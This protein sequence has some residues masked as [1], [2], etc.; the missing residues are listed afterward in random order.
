MR[1]FL[2]LLPILLAGCS[3][4]AF[5]QPRSEATPPEVT[6]VN[7]SSEKNGESPSKKNTGRKI[8][9][10]AEL[11]L[12]VEDFAAAKSAVA[13]EVASV[14]GHIEQHSVDRS[15]GDQVTGQ[16]IL[17]TP[18]SEFESVLQSLRDLGV[19]EFE[20]IN[21]TDKTA[22]H[23]DLTARIASQQTL[24]QRLLTLLGEKADDLKSIIEL[25]T[26]LSEVRRQIE[27]LQA[28]LRVL[29]DQIAMTTIT[30]Q[31][32]EEKN[33]TPP[34]AP[35][36]AAQIS[37][38]FGVSVGAMLEA[39]KS[40]VL[41]LVAVGPWLLAGLVLSSPFLFWGFVWRQRQTT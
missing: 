32:R 26:K 6:T 8:V 13:K 31:A 27:T 23:V 1:C 25:E 40:L 38:V 7:Q 9:Y 16:W 28:T 19:P 3:H 37:S 10:K 33:Y 17:R 24:E 29:D 12:V 20:Q 36:F 35:T 18:V 15:Y 34:Q 5:D 4:N 2:L 14:G 39:G 30:L 22:Q 11:N 41:L 21:A